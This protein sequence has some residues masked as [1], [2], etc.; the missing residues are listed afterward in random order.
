M[1]PS[2]T[3]II[4]AGISTTALSFG[5]AASAMTLASSGFDVG[6]EGWAAVNGSTQIQSVAAGGAAGGYVRASDSATGALWFFNAPASFLGDQSA[7]YAAD[8]SFSLRSELVSAPL[9]GSYA[10]V[11]LLGNNGLL[12]AWSSG[13]NPGADWTPYSV[14][15]DVTAGWTKGSLS[16]AAASEAEIRS[17][18]GSLKALRIRGDYGQAVD[19]TGLDSVSI[20]AAVPE[21]S[22]ALLMLLGVGGLAAVQA[23]RRRGADT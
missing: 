16:G 17:V 12:L 23:R 3:R 10:Q 15:F 9:S 5:T 1:K 8:L 6:T 19:T 13:Q 4:L 7:A 11:Q 14:S 2:F 22:A 20:T 21:P 18:L